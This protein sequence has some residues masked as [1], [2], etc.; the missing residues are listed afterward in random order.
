MTVSLVGRKI[1]IVE[2][3][4]FLASALRDAVELLGGQ[5]VG[6]FARLQQALP[7]I[8]AGELPDVGL[9]DVNLGS[10]YSYPLADAL[11]KHGIPTVLITGYDP[12]ALPEAYR[13]L[14]YLRKPFDLA[15]VSSALD[16]LAVAARG[17]QQAAH[18]R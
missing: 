11:A 15:S 13:S 10:E 7:L 14:S 8:E 9:L 1:L 17:E 16:S 4:Y 3:E 12:D 5:V 18:R 6:P 2:D